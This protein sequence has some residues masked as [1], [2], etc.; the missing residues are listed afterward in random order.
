MSLRGRLLIFI[1]KAIGFLL[2]GAVI[3]YFI[4]PAYNRLLLA[5]ISV[6]IP[7]DPMLVL[8]QDTIYIYAQASTQPA[9][10]IYI[11]A[12]HYGLILVIALI[13]ATPGMKLL[14][15]LKF[16][17]IALV[18]IFA[19]HLVSVVL[20]TQTALSATTHSMGQNPLIVLF[21]IIGADLFPVVVWAG[22][23]Y[24]YFIT[25]PA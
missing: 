21:A 9:G 12:L 13:L 4:A 25:K 20:F 22:L 14:Q 3:W 5:T 8:R 24:K 23:S 1:G 10:G 16:T 11:S 2:A 7:S 18:A 19:V 15:R 17:S 6:L